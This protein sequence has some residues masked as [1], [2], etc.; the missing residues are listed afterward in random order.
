[1]IF[2]VNYLSFF[3]NFTGRGILTTADI[4]LT[5]AVSMERYKAICKPLT[6]RHPVYLYLI[7]VALISVTLEIPLFFEFETNPNGT[8]YWT[9]FLN[10]EIVYIR[11]NSF[12]N[13]LLVSGGVQTS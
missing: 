9:T 6:P 13:E 7:F 10:E 12:W 4:F 2:C 8:D 5:I 1:M 3:C 11:M